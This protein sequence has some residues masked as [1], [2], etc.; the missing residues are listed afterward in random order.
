MQVLGTP[1]REEIKCMNPNYTEFKFP[2]IKAHPWHKVPADTWII[3]LPCLYKKARTNYMN[4]SSICLHMIDSYSTSAC[5]MKLWTLSPDY[6]NIL[7]TSEAQLW[8]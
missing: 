7:Q 8:V 5:P 6:Y 4:Y 1:T 2:Q 3:I